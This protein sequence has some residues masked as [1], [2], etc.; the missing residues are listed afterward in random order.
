[1]DFDHFLGEKHHILT[2]KGNGYKK[3]PVSMTVLAKKDMTEFNEE[4]KKC[5]IVCANCHRI[6]TADRR[7][8]KL[9]ENKL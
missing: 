4:L 9:D 6:R 5:E 7:R 3:N 8:K 2:H 1:M